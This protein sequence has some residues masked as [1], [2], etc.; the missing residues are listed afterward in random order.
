MK[1]AAS[2]TGFWFLSSTIPE[3]VIFLAGFCPNEIWK[4]QRTIITVI[5]LLIFFITYHN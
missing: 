2:F 4:K 3:I 1:I 5:M